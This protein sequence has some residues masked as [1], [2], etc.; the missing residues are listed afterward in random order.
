M[1]FRFHVPRRI[2]SQ[3]FTA[4]W[5]LFC[6]LWLAYSHWSVAEWFCNSKSHCQEKQ[7]KKQ[8][9]TTT[10]ERLNSVTPSPVTPLFVIYRMNAPQQPW[11]PKCERVRHAGLRS[12]GE[13]AWERV[14]TN[15]WV[16]FVSFVNSFYF[17][18]PRDRLKEKWLHYETQGIYP[19]SAPEQ[20][21][22]LTH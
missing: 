8:K 7:K 3:H 14:D 10:I 16:K 13:Q 5:A 12:E 17:P 19:G 4:R 20:I 21:V 15:D 6:L 2:K 11:I 22:R 9:K 18:D 1:I